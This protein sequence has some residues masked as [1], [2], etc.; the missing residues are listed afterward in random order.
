MAKSERKKLTR[1]E[2]RDLD[3]EIDFL[4][5]LARRAP[6]YVDALELLG[7]DYTRRGRFK[8]GLQVDLQLVTLRPG[9]PLVHYNLACSYSLTDQPEKAFEALNKALDCGYR[10]FHWLSRDPDLAVFREHPLYRKL[11]TRVRAMRV[12]VD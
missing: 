3:I 6:D 4:A 5:G 12:P 2:E 9:N 1:A 8:D 10:D 7:E 11:R